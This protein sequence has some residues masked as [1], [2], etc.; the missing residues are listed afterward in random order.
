MRICLHTNFEIGF[1]YIGGTQTFLIKLAKELLV[2]GHDPFIVCSSLTPE[3]C[4]EGIKIFGVIP[5]M[6]KKKL[7]GEYN[8]VFSS[9]FLYDQIF[10]NR[11]PQYALKEL[12]S[13]TK[14]QIQNF[15]ADVFHLNSF[16]SAAYLQVDFYDKF[17]IT[18]NE[19]DIEC[20]GLWGNGFFS[21][22]KDLVYNKKTFLHK[23]KIL[24]TPS[25]YYANYLSNILDLHIRNIALGVLLN[26]Y[27]L[28]SSYDIDKLKD[29]HS[30]NKEAIVLLV[31][32]RFNVKQKGQDIAIEACEHLCSLFNIGLVFSGVKD[33]LYDNIRLFQNRY[34][35][36]KIRNNVHF[37]K[38]DSMMKLY[39]I[40]DIVISPERYCSYG[41]SISESLALGIP[42]ILSDIPTY[43]EIAAGYCH[44]FF[45]PL[46]DIDALADTI[47]ATLKKNHKTF[48]MYEDGI[49]FRC[50]NDFRETA[51]KYSNLYY[52]LV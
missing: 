32:S 50:N 8:G 49:R 14:F 29:E 22:F 48:R 18:N 30:I 31:P 2:L 16:V 41:L 1:P 42:T 5:E 28:K 44:A 12:S 35:N 25:Y 19:N 33:S 13:Y 27:M 15:D 45:F 38:T 37:V 46:N 26:D 24:C 10:K 6:Y 34:K 40:S 4:I 9:R 23:F 3:Y 21:I 51:K 11:T 47:K 36:Y 52:E 7:L 43:R 39:S 20:D 17:I